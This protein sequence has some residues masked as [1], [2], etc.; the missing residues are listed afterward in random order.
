MI[1]H[2]GDNSFLELFADNTKPGCRQY[3]GELAVKENS[4]LTGATG[5]V[6]LKRRQ[7]NS[8]FAL[9]RGLKLWH[10]GRDSTPFCFRGT[11]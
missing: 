8:L 2:G 10:D 7:A 5:F 9:F 6:D 3:P 11:P 4:A 1:L